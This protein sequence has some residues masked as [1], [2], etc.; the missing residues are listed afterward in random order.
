MSIIKSSINN[1]KSEGAAAAVAVEPMLTP[2]EAVAQLR[3]LRERIPEFLQ[4]P[5]TRSTRELRR[6]ARLNVE[7]TREAFG[8]VGASEVVQ[9]VIGNSPDELHQAETEMARWIAVESELNAL[10]R[11]VAAANL[12]RRERLA[13]AALQAYNVSSQLVKQEEYAFL[14]PHVERMRRLPKF[15]RRRTRVAAEPES[16]APPTQ[17]RSA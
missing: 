3:A 11:G 5:N 10:L 14:L 12:V 1:N 15:G 16:P 2:E 9:G 7:F 6:K 8:V 13:Q 4:L 17:T